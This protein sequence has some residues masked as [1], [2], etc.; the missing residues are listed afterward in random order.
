MQLVW[1]WISWNT[2]FF[3]IETKIGNDKNNLNFERKVYDD[4]AIIIP[5]G[6][7]HNF[8]NTGN[9]PIKLYS[10]YAPP[11]HPKRTV[12]RTKADAEHE[13]KIID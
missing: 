4:F 13:Q 11:N 8:T 12:H 2:Y 1:N 10:I 7:W 9:V 3:I 6:K 5:A